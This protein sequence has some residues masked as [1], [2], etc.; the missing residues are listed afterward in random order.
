MMRGPRVL[1]PHVLRARRRRGGR[2]EPRSVPWPLTL[3]V[4]LVQLGCLL[5]VGLVGRTLHAAPIAVTLLAAAAATGVTVGVVRR[6]ESR[7]IMENEKLE[8][9]VR[10]RSAALLKTRDAVIFGLARLAESRDDQTGHH[11]ERIRQY[12]RVLACELSRKYPE[13]TPEYIRL[14]ELTSALHDVGKVGVPDAVLL[15]PG[16]L[17]ADELEIMRKHPLIGGDCLLAVKQRLGDDDFLETACEIAFAHH[18]HWDGSGYPFGLA[19]EDIPLSARIVALADVYDALTTRRV[20]KEA[21]SHEQARE[22]I[23]AASGRQFD[24]DVVAAFLARE[25]DFRRIAQRFSEQP[26]PREVQSAGTT[27]RNQGVEVAS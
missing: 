12:V 22:I 3:T 9:L 21:M 18:E 14:L 10:R 1:L 11:L 20:Y 13:L 15:K 4:L 24:P 8:A 7:L 17:D 23:V 26:L 6:Y 16:P 25:D 2:P 27:E 19:G 5:A